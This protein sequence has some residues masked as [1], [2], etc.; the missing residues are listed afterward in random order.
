MWTVNYSGTNWYPTRSLLWNCWINQKMKRQRARRGMRVCCLN[1]DHRC[2][3]SNSFGCRYNI[4]WNCNQ[5]SRPIARRHICNSETHPYLTQAVRHSETYTNTW[6]FCINE[7]FIPP[8]MCVSMC[9]FWSWRRCCSR[10]I[11]KIRTMGN[12]MVGLGELLPLDQMRY[13]LPDMFASSTGIKLSHTIYYTRKL[14]FQI[15]TRH[16]NTST[17]SPET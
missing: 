7:F 2:T 17:R 4:S 14:L 6:S 11:V 5:L 9:A 10:C 13:T 15:H 3:L 1:F 8:P 12:I 16:I